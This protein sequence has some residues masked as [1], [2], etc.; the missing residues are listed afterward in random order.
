[1]VG[2]FSL[3]ILVSSLFQA[4]KCRS[5]V[6]EDNIGSVGPI[7]RLRQKTNLATPKS[8]SLPVS[9]S[10]FSSRGTG[11]GPDATPY[12]IS[13]S[14][15]L[16]SFDES[17]HKISKTVG[18]NEN[19][20]MPGT[21]YTPVPSRSTEMA[22][23]ILQQLEKLVPKEKSYEGKVAAAREKSQNK[24]TTNMVGGQA[25]RILEDVDSSKILH[26]AEDSHKLKDT[27]NSSLP[28][29]R[30]TS[31]Q[32]KVEENAPKRVIISRDALAPAGISNAI[33]SGKEAVP[34]VNTAAAVSAQFP[35]QLSQKK[36][37]FQ[38]SAHEVCDFPFLGSFSLVL[39]RC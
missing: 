1:M 16:P 24:L 5:F 32:K 9:G 12:P 14:Q 33:V 4:L 36:W 21:S 38:M 10:P 7:R 15:K 22:T 3:C 13:S 34:G 23:K 29:A 25:L 2:F 31:S 20:G 11:I 28:N 37:G 6:L 19:N 30:D 18:E 35:T 26:N 27:C 8:L 17:K 39:F